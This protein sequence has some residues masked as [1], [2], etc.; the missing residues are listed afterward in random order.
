MPQDIAINIPGDAPKGEEG[1]VWLCRESWGRTAEKGHRT[2]SRVPFA[3]A[4]A[5]LHMGVQHGVDQVHA[6]VSVL[7]P[8]VSVFCHCHRKSDL[9][10]KIGHQTFPFSSLH[11]QTQEWPVP[12][13]PPAWSCG[14]R[15][16]GRHMS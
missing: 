15:D 8:H 1:I 12:A 14:K 5:G 16:K 10:R 6:C 13:A 9:V 4:M 3:A 2:Q 7:Q 11:A